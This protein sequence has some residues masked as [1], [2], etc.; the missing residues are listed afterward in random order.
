MLKRVIGILFLIVILVGVTVLS[1][2]SAETY[3]EK[4]IKMIIGFS[5]GGPTDVPARIVAESWEK[6]IGTNFVIT[7]KTG[8]G[9]QLAWDE[10]VNAEPDGY[11][12]GVTNVPGMI[13]VSL[14]PEANFGASDFDYIGCN[15]VDSAGIMVKAD[16]EYETIEQL[17]DYMEANPG[18]V[19]VGLN[20]PGTDD[21]LAQVMFEE[22]WGRAIQSIVPFPE[23]EADAAIALLGGHIDAMFGNVS[24]ADNHPGEIRVLTVMNKERLPN[25][26][27]VPTVGEILGK[28]VVEF[29][30]RGFAAPKGIP[31]D[32]L[33]ILRE[34]FKKAVENP[35]TID[36]LEKA[37]FLTIYWGAEEFGGNV[38]MLDETVRRFREDLGL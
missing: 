5:A 25:Y 29:S 16:S 27:D 8:A 15:I 22:V 38:L 13:I 36:K 1:G 34:S 32:R 14:R 9:G 37:G 4:P 6:E 18:K 35:E 24:T 12:I 20:A 21:Q 11:T 2:F 28:D 19:I 3:P 30:A 23:G 31:E 7:N 10:L 33:N 26:P 17:L